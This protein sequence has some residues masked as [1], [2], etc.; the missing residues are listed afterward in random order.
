MEALQESYL[1]AIV[2]S[3]GC[4]VVGKPEIDEGV[5]LEIKHTS[6][7]HTLSDGVARLEIQMKATSVYAG[8]ATNKISVKMSGERFNHFAV[9]NPTM[10]KIVVIMSMPAKQEHWTYSRRKGLTIHHS[11]YWVNLAG[12]N[13]V[14]TSQTNVSAP[15]LQVFDDVA[16][17]DMMERIGRG[18]PP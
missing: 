10:D 6:T 7:A 4:V 1:R 3:A 14:I 8:V 12:E 18:D 16:L 17:C 11:A 13:P 15:T 9:K 2:A 5:D